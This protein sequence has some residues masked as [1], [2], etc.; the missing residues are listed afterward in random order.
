LLNQAE[1]KWQVSIK[2]IE[3]DYILDCADQETQ[4]GAITTAQINS[5]HQID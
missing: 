1:I 3:K 4:T 2:I 5:Y